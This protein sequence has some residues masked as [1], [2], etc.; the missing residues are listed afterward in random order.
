MPPAQ[1]SIFTLLDPA[2][3][4][5]VVDIGANPID[6]D[7]P[8][9]ALLRSGQAD[10][11]GFEPNRD[12]HAVLL[13]KKGP[14]ETYLPLAISDGE[15]HTLHHCQASGMTSLLEPNPD[16]LSLFH[17]FQE[18][19]RVIRTEPV[20]TV[21]LDDVRETEGVDFIKIDI[22]GAELLALSNATAR[23]AGALVVQS[24]VEFLKMYR[25]QPLFQD[26]AQFLAGHGFVLH[27]FEPLV[28]RVVKPMLLGGNI[29]AG[30]SQ[31]LW[32]DA[33]FV[34]D[35]VRTDALDDGQL[36]RIAVILHEVYGS[37]DLALHYLLARDRLTGGDLGPRYL[38][39]IAGR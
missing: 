33:I 31:V 32:T 7:P 29:R 21:R 39:A 25:D 12:A 15:R 30:F 9:A 17:G 36:L 10:L 28:S 19:S 23:L 5:R 37:I 8:Y 6:G 35:P 20:D 3:R 14:H 27:K 38:A 24:E 2:P 16:V 11:V 18:W 22:Q 13:R 1:P 4:I 26:V 34:R